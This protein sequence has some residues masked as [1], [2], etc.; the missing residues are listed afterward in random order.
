MKKCNNVMT[1]DPVCCL[2]SDSVQSAAKMMKDTDVGPIPV[3]DDKSA[4]KLVGIITDRDLAMRVVAEGLDPKSTTV[5]QAMTSDVFSC[6]ADDDLQKAVDAMKQY[7]LRR[8]PIVTDGGSICG[9]ISQA[10]VAL[11]QDNEGVTAKVVEQ[12]SH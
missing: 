3:I 8:I 6:H 10:D 2:S 7:Q 12:I 5:E 1:K 11:R 4:K 9:I